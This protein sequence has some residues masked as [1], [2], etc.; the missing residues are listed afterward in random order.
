MIKKKD[1]DKEEF[2]NAAKIVNGGADYV[3]R[4][5]KALLGV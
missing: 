3:S 2:M 1:H 5:N 4:R